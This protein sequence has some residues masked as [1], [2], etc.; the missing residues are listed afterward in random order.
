MAALVIFGLG[1]IVCAVAPSSNVFIFGRSIQGI[2]GAGIMSGGLNIVADL[3]PQEKRPMYLALIASVYAFAGA[4]GPP[5][6]GI[7]VDS[8]L[9]WRFAFWINLPLIFVAGII[10]LAF[11]NEPQRERLRKGLKE[12]LKE[13]QILTSLFLAGVMACLFFALQRGGVSHAWSSAEVWPFLLV[14]AVGL[15]VFIALQVRQGD[16]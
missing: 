15:L 12:K 11:Y 10:L 6:G 16:K 14:F 5:V 9:T 3:A 8:K 7:F 2:G 4:A 13:L 1:S